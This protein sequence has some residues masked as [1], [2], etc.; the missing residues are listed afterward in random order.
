M[1]FLY[2]FLGD[3]YVY[4]RF[5]NSELVEALLEFIGEGDFELKG[6]FFE[7]FMDKDEMKGLLNLLEL[8]SYYY[9]QDSKLSDYDF[10]VAKSYTKRLNAIEELQFEI[11]KLCN[12]GK[13]VEYFIIAIE[14]EHLALQS[15]INLKLSEAVE[16]LMQLSK[17]QTSHTY[18]HDIDL[19]AFV[20][21]NFFDDLNINWA[22]GVGYIQKQDDLI[23]DKYLPL[24]GFQVSVTTE[25][26]QYFTNVFEVNY[27]AYHIYRNAKDHRYQYKQK[28][29]QRSYRFIVDQKKAIE[30]NHSNE[31]QFNYRVEEANNLQSLFNKK[32]EQSLK[33]LFE[34]NQT[35]QTTFNK[36]AQYYEKTMQLIDDFVESDYL[37]IIR[38][39]F[40]LGHINVEEYG[41]HFYLILK[42]KEQIDEISLLQFIDE[43]KSE[44]LTRQAGLLKAFI[45]STEIAPTAGILEVQQ[46]TVQRTLMQIEEE[47]GYSELYRS[48]DSLKEFYN[49][50]LHKK[51]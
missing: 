28:R 5:L 2:K 17:N 49:Q 35:I 6:E 20:E 12:E 37:V 26:K 51:N 23:E 25:V 1:V 11:A 41:Y 9:Y 13:E 38:V 10:E 36:N 18:A 31:Q 24:K 27:V 44:I 15:T 14:K 33:K 45:T 47:R 40:L 34:L 43:A 48:D 16:Q 30:V 32:A 3:S 8:E 42:L 39:Y 29:A 22:W 19:P 46:S 4:N 7:C 21:T 50:Q